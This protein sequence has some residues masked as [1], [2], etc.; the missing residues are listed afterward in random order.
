MALTVARAARRFAPVCFL[1]LLAT[2]VSASGERLR[3]PEGP[4]GPVAASLS[5]TSGS[6]SESYK[7]PTDAAVF[8]AGDGYRGMDA[9]TA[10]QHD[11]LVYTYGPM[12]HGNSQIG[13]W[14][15]NEGACDGNGCD[16]D[17]WF[18]KSSCIGKCNDC[19]CTKFNR[20]GSCKNTGGSNL[21]GWASSAVA[22]S[23][24]GERFKEGD[25]VTF[26]F[27]SVTV[28]RN[29]H[30]KWRVMDKTGNC[31]DHVYAC[32]VPSMFRSCKADEFSMKYRD[33]DA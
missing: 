16:I 23:Y 14:K 7:A 9:L 28:T 5:E 21:P 3:G 13:A 2:A 26:P 10:P 24:N 4:Q 18:S 11:A 15:Y 22:P 19:C 32:C 6:C 30:G 27:G 33:C 29:A 17:F 20:D 8:D 1:F 25:S 31:L 12:F